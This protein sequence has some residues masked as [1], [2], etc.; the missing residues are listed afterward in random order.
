MFLFVGSNCGLWINETGNPA[1][2]QVKI[3]FL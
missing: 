3:Y 2:P 1:A